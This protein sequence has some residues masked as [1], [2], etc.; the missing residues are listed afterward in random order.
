M[1]GDDGGAVEMGSRY[2]LQMVWRGYGRKSALTVGLREWSNFP[3]LRPFQRLAS[4]IR[5]WGRYCL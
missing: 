3:K 1:A 2:N 4:L 5:F